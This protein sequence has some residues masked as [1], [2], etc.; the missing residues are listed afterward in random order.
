MICAG[1][2]VPDFRRGQ[3]SIALIPATQSL[4]PRSAGSAQV[5]HRAK[6][7]E[8]YVWRHNCAR[9]S[10]PPAQ[11]VGIARTMSTMAYHLGPS[12]GSLFHMA[13][14]PAVL[15]MKPRKP[16]MSACI[17]GRSGAS[18]AVI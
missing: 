7:G 16:R 11:A 2:E 9:Q 12:E 3:Q 10:A 6:A 5:A 14:A 4:E 15:A 17:K 8:S 13:A 18:L 1:Y